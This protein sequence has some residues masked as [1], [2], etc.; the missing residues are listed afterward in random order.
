MLTP[1]TARS[2]TGD[3]S[4]LAHGFLHARRAAS[5]RAS[6]PPSTVV[7][8]RATSAARVL[9]N[10]RAS[11]TASGC[12][13]AHLLTCHQVHSAKRISPTQSRGRPKAYTE[14]RCARH[15]RLRAWR[16]PFWP[17]IAPR[18]CSPMPMRGSSARRMPAGEVRWA[19]FWKPPSPPWSALGARR[20]R[21]RGRARTLHR[22]GRLR[23]RR[24]IRGALPDPRDPPTRRFFHRAGSP[25]ARAFRPARLR[26]RPAGA[27]RL[28]EVESATQMHVCL[29]DAI[30]SSATGARPTARNRDYGRQISAIVL[31]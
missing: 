15:C 4:G 2:L 24:G 21:I 10:R 22:P 31:R 3:G 27:R 7:W 29:N 23:G 17:P 19:A 13:E 8:A 6:T 5:R 9:E 26:H 11:P 28:G 12:R 16:S 1:I 25:G 20:Q 14:G 30:S 18:C